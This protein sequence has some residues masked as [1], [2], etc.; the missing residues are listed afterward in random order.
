MR[1]WGLGMDQWLKD[2]NSL[3][4]FH[5]A[6]REIEAGANFEAGQAH[7][8]PPGGRPQGAGGEGGKGGEE[9]EGGEEPGR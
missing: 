9:G 8:E 6:C 4:V 7:Q 1:G 2:H 5:Q 3:F